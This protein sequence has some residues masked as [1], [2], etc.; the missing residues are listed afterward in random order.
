MTTHHP[1]KLRANV[2]WIYLVLVA[3]YGLVLLLPS[4]DFQPVITAGDIGRDY[5]AYERTMRGDAPYRDYWWVYGPLMPYY[6]AAWLK[7]FGVRIPVL[8]A[9]RMV[10]HLLSGLFLYGA[11]STI[12]PPFAA[13]LGAL[14]FWVYYPGFFHT[15]N[16]DGGITLALAVVCALFFYARRRSRATFA[17]G[18]AAAFLLTLVKLNFGFAAVVLF[19]LCVAA[20]DASRGEPVGREDRVLLAAGLLGVPA[21]SLAIHALFVH[22]MP[23]YEVR[24]CFPF[25]GGDYPYHATPIK[26]LRVLFLD[27]VAEMRLS[28]ARMA[29]AAVVALC[30]LKALGALLSSKTGPET[31]RLRVTA[32][33]VPAVFGVAFLHEYLMSGVLYN[34]LWADPFWILLMFVVI[35]AAY[36]RLHAVLAAVL[37]A[38]L[39]ALALFGYREKAEAQGAYRTPEH[40]L[41][42]PKAGVYTANTPE[43]TETVTETVGYLRDHLGKDEAFLALP[44]EPLYYYLA[45]RASPTRQ[46]IFFRHINI[47]EGQETRIISDVERANVRFVVASGRMRSA[48]REMGVLGDTHCPQLGRYLDRNF[49]PVARFPR[50]AKGRTPAPETGVTIFKRVPP[51]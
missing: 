30:L 7:V 32:L 22:G 19:V 44:Y 29:T 17:A 48:A 20:I 8:L 49:K 42:L 3:V 33:L 13:T 11:L 5:Y 46:L 41:D 9:G 35:G 4:I 40:F 15:Y 27:G 1:I 34:T 26:A 37:C 31:R 28:P 18:L 21:L 2:R 14:W 16:H 38:S 43:W 39:L 25:L 23:L 51:S 24:Q 12:A 36:D 10:L 45:D 50:S 6:Y 47:T